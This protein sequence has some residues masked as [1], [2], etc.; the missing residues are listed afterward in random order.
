M[1]IQL[2]LVWELFIDTPLSLSVAIFSIMTMTML[3]KRYDFVLCLPCP[4]LSCHLTVTWFLTTGLL[5]KIRFDVLLFYSFASV[6]CPWDPGSS[7]WMIFFSA[8]QSTIHSMCQCLCVRDFPVLSESSQKNIFLSADCF[9]FSS[10]TLSVPC[11]LSHDLSL[12]CKPI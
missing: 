1:R 8:L 3:F 7:L 6:F 12:F 11:S 9:I 4:T 10:V 5:R 2:F